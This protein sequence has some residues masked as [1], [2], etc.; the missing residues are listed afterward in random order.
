[1]LNKLLT[2]PFFIFIFCVPLGIFCLLTMIQRL[3]AWVGMYGEWSFKQ[4][5]KKHV[6]LD[7]RWI[8][9]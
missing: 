3:E 9:E 4:W 7:E 5:E 6:E 2:I 1:M 8:D